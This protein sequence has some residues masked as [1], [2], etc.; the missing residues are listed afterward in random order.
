MAL[1]PQKFREI[2][3]HLLY[4]SDFGEWGDDELVDLIMTQLVVTKKAVREARELALQVRAK[5]E[6]LDR[7][8]IKQSK[9]Y[10]F[11]RIP[12]IER[13]VLRLGIYEM[14]YSATVPTKVAIAEAIRLTRKFA[15]PESATFVNAILDTI[16]HTDLK[17]QEEKKSHAA[18]P[19]G[20]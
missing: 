2:V 7:L 5:Q 15:S 4:S 17:L 20:V 11:E 3:F 18:T 14:F 8:I 16:Y 1:S 12:R 6:D 10:D 13:N 9:G 19:I